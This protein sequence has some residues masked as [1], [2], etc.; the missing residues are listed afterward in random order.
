MPAT[1]N[2]AT[3]FADDGAQLLRRD[4]PSCSSGKQGLTWQAYQQLSSNH[5]AQSHKDANKQYREW[6]RE[7]SRG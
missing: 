6:N 1:W 4:L 2:S 5:D 7:H 3:A